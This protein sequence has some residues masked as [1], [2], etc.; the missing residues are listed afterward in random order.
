MI[1]L[2]DVQFQANSSGSYWS[3]ERKNMSMEEV[4]RELTNL[5][6]KAPR[7]ITSISIKPVK[8]HTYEIQLRGMRHAT[9]TV[10]IEAESDTEARGIALRMKNIPWDTSDV[11]DVQVETVERLP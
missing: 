9:A 11:E 7:P 1:Q 6:D 8:R 5:Q 2:F 4:T 10:R 3:F